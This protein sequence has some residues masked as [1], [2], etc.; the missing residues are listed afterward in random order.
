M[1]TIAD[2][3]LA[4]SAIC[5]S[6]GL[7]MAAPPPEPEY[8]LFLQTPPAAAVNSVTISSAGSLV[9]TAAGEGGVRLYNAHTGAFLRSI[10]DMGDRG[11]VFSPAGR[12]ITAA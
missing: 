10:G 6:T 3:L 1:R 9:A 5:M 8:K 12:R 7:L 4:W 2:W 11:V